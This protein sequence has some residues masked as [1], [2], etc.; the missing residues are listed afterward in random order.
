[1]GEDCQAHSDRSV[2]SSVAAGRQKSEAI[3]E[4]PEK[5]V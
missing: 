5:L 1:M 2:E 4:D 3:F